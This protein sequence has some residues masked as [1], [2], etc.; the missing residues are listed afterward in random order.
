MAMKKQ[1]QLFKAEIKEASGLLS[2]LRNEYPLTYT[3]VAGILDRLNELVW[4]M[5]ESSGLD[6]KISLMLEELQSL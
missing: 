6:K 2:R 1:A 4:E 3:D 5:R